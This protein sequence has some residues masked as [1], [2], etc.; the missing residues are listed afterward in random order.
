MITSNCFNWAY[1]VSIGILLVE[2]LSRTQAA[3]KKFY[4][5]GL[6]WMQTGANPIKLFTDVI[7]V[8]S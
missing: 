6:S 4:N 7:F 3:Q 2:H 5:V 1:L 8:I